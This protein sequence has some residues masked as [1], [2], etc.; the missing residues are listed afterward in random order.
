[1]IVLPFYRLKMIDKDGS[2]TYSMIRN[3]KFSDL[4][5]GLINIFPNPAVNTINLSVNAEAKGN[6]LLTIVNMHG[7]KIL[8][9]TRMVDK[10]I[11]NFT[12]DVRNLLKATYIVSIKNII[13]GE[14][15]RQNFQKL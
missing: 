2:F 13:T 9:K 1:M 8:Q 14:E 11:N 15:T 3:I 4:R 10:G 6:V 7:Q 12:E 5:N